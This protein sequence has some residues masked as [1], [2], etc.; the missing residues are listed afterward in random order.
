M[1]C[2]VPYEI[3]GLAKWKNWNACDAIKSSRGIS[4]MINHEI[5][6]D[7]ASHVR[8]I[9][10]RKK[11]LEMR[12]IPT[13]HWVYFCLLLCAYVHKVH[14]YPVYTLKT[15][16]FV[17]DREES[18]VIS[19][20]QRNWCI[21]SHTVWQLDNLTHNENAITFLFLVRVRHIFPHKDYAVTAE[22]RCLCS[23]SVLC[24]LFFLRSSR[25][26][27]KTR[28]LQTFFCSISFIPRRT[29]WMGMFFPSSNQM[30][31]WCKKKVGVNKRPWRGAVVSC[32]VKTNATNRLHN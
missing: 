27:A 19:V 17:D 6:R 26:S 9:R 11:R 32:I 12:H 10:F 30:R 14:G 20:S 24:S 15:Q 3:L 22:T 16:L 8:G 21:A 25:I 28:C 18:W 29:S 23:W 7:E 5:V 4:K 13:I 31:G 2:G 1:M